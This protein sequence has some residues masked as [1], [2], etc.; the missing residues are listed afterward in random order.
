MNGKGRMTTRARVAAGVGAVAASLSIAGCRDT[1][2]VI[3][4][5]IW[6]MA[7]CIECIS[8]E[9]ANVVAMGD[10]A[11]PALRYLLLHGPPDTTL[12]R[13]DSALSAPYPAPPPIAG[14]IT[15]P[16]HL[17][18]LRLA[19][20]VAIYRMRSS[21]ALGLIGTDS[22]KRTLCAAR[23]S[24]FRADVQRVIDSSL[25]LLSGQCP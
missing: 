15:P 13:Q 14:T 5:R 12:A 8:H 11:I 2:P 7:R 10:S 20:F 1:E 16:D 25:V 6:L 21:L 18:D 24:H 23:D 9:Q 17:V 19:D 4:R 22:A 3:D